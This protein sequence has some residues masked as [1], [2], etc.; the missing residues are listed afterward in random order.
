[1][2]FS[3]S[4]PGRLG[5]GRGRRRRRTRMRRSKRCPPELSSIAQLL[6]CVFAG[7]GGVVGGGKFSGADVV[8]DLVQG[9]G[10]RFEVLLGLG[11][12]EGG[13]FIECDMKAVAGKPHSERVTLARTK[14]FS[15]F[16]VEVDCELPL[17][18][19]L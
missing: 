6:E 7:G 2:K 13:S 15:S 14:P 5:R 11:Q 12:I 8:G 16:E 4:K 1:M 10:P 19:G 3:I 9:G 18:V 17:V